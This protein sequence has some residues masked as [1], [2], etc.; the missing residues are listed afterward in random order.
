MT[1]HGDILENEEAEAMARA[2]VDRAA[3]TLQSFCADTFVTDAL[4]AYISARITKWVPPSVKMTRVYIEENI[5]RSRKRM[6]VAAL[7]MLRFHWLSFGIFHWTAPLLPATLFGIDTPKHIHKIKDFMLTVCR[8]DARSVRIKR[9]KDKAVK[10]KERVDAD[11]EDQGCHQVQGALLH[12]PL[13]ALCLRHR[14][15]QQAQ[16]VPPTRDGKV[17]SE[18]DMLSLPYYIPPFSTMVV[19][20]GGYSKVDVAIRMY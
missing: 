14:E 10:F 11:Q 6:D 8:K 12:V 3:G 1:H 5:N 2:A 17:A 13:H 16:A 19:V 7:D 20:A 4:L 18:I 9:T 15:S